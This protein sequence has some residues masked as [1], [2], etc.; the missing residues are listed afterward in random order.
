MRTAQQGQDEFQDISVKPLVCRA[1]DRGWNGY[2]VC[3]ENNSEG[4][5]CGHRVP[6]GSEALCDNPVRISQI[7][8]GRKVW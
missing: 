4:R 1:E 2:I 3:L 7:R 8:N 5:T 6:F